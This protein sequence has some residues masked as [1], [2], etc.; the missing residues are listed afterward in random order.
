MAKADADVRQLEE[1]LCHLEERASGFNAPFNVAGF[2]IPLQGFMAPRP[3]L[4]PG[5][6]GLTGGVGNWPPGRAVAPFWGARCLK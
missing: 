4:E 3:G 1:F 2:S 6:Y 5:N